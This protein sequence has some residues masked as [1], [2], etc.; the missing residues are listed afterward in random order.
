[1]REVAILGIGQT[2]FGELWDRSFREIGIEAGFAALQEA[3]LSSKDISALYLGNMAS[4]SFIEQ[5]HIAPLILDYAG[6]AG[7]HL[8]AIRVEAGGASGAVALHQAYLAVASGAHDYVVV[9]GAEKMTD[10]P[11]DVQTDIAN[12][13][14][15]QEWETVFGATLP[16]LWA[17]IARRHMHDHGTR[18]ED[19]ARFPV[20]AHEMGSKN[21]L[22]HFRNKVSLDQ[23]LEGSPVAQPLGVMDCA[24]ASDGASA[25]VLGPLEKA[26]EHT[27]TPIRICASQVACDT[28]A[29]QHRKDITTVEATRLAAQVAFRHAKRTPADVQVAEIHDAY[30]ISAL[31]ALE[32]LGFCPKG[33]VGKALAEG[34]VGPPGAR[35]AINSSGGLK[36]QGQPFG[37]VGVAQVAEVVRQLRGEA[38]ERQVAGAQVG[39]THNLGGTGATSVVH[40]LERAT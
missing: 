12:A 2:K 13:S 5:E 24:P 14:A 9:G 25:L 23:V 27:D 18:R 10:V 29:L 31:L 19:F 30:S 16:S 6:L 22:A 26:R 21:P 35:L 7:H 15:D 37:A 3:K 8:P 40:L 28:L 32:D 38:K 4:G 1:M 36:A 39:L 17:L 34:T 20:L 11:E 33:G